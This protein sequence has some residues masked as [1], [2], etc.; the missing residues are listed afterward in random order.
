MNQSMIASKPFFLDDFPSLEDWLS[1]NGFFLVDQFFNHESD[2]V[3]SRWTN[4]TM[5]E[6]G[7]YEFSDN[8]RFLIITY[9]KTCKKIEFYNRTLIAGHDAGMKLFEELQMN[10]SGIS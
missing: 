2:S 3:F 9:C 10:L 7:Q 5:T 4:I 1:I 6:K 8:D